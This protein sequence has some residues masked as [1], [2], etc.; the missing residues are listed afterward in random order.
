LIGKFINNDYTILGTG[1]AKRQFLYANDL[2]K[3]IILIASNPVQ[4]GFK[5][6]IVSPPVSEE[7]TIWALATKIKAILG[8]HF[9]TIK[10]DTTFP[11]GQPQKTVDDSEIRELFP[12]FVF[13]SLDSGLKEVINHVRPLLKDTMEI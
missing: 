1:S 6:V 2:A 5:D 4:Y 12:R 8:D 10:C 3:I 11:D 9:Q 7:L 13:T